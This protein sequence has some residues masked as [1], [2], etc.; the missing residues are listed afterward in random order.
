MISRVREHREPSRPG[1]RGR[2]DDR[3]AQRCIPWRRSNAGH[4]APLTALAT[5][6]FCAVVLSLTLILAVGVVDFWLT[7]NNLRAHRHDIAL[8]LD[9]S[10]AR[11]ANTL[12]SRLQL[13]HGLAG[14]AKTQ[15]T[16]SQ[17]TFK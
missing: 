14:F 7:K 4:A 17:S 1:L 12:N 10:R 15:P 5:P 9:R 11:L 2:V 8:Q 16:I 3:V 13:A 6:G